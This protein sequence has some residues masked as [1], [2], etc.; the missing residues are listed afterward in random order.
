MPRTGR[1]K[2]DNPKRDRVTI[3]F[4]EE[5]ISQLEAYADKYHLM[6]SQV[7]IKCFDELLRQEEEANKSK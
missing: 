4:S 3:R 6:K 1:P 5:Q 2:G 7:L